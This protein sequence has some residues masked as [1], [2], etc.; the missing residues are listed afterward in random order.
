[1]NNQSRMSAA[2]LISNRSRKVHEIAELRELAFPA[3]RANAPLWSV[4][5]EIEKGAVVRARVLL[6]SALVEELAALMIMHY[7]LDDCDRW[8]QLRYFGRVKKYRVLYEDA[9]G[10]LPARQKLAIVRKFAFV[11]RAHVT[12]IT[13]ILALRDVLA[14]VY[15]FSGSNTRAL[16]YKGHSVFGRPGLDLYVQDASAVIDWLLRKVRLLQ[17]AHSAKD[18]RPKDGRPSHSGER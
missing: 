14:H 2:R 4:R 15:T 13:R 7:V 17:S 12:A 16:H 5:L 1:M 9:L 8:R 10:R 11:P 6:D 3:P 18:G